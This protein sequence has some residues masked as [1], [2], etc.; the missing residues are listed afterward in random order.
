MHRFLQRRG[1]SRLPDVECDK[2]AKKKFRSY[3]ISY[4]HIDIAKV[5]TTEGKL[6]P[7]VAIDR[8]SKFAY[9][10]LYK[11]A[12][13]MTAAEFLHH[14]IQTLPY[15]VRT[16]CLA[17]IDSVFQD[18]VDRCGA[19]PAAASGPI[20]MPVQPD[21][22]RLAPPTGP[23]APSRYKVKMRRTSSASTGSMTSTFLS[24]LL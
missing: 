19:K 12:N 22:D 20:T 1:I 4:F 7:F 6:Y 2:P 24:R 14:L 18:H 9:V 21:R 11:R 15:Q 17:N 10:E 13:K 5:Q 16:S 23:L 3:P 8:T